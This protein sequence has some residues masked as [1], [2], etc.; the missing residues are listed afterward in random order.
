[1]EYINN[2][3]KEVLKEANNLNLPV[4]K[5]IKND[6]IINK[7]AKS[8]FGCCKKI[9]KGL[10]ESYELELSD[11][12]LRCEEK[13]I[14]QTLAHEI[15]HTCPGCGNHG[16]L[17][18]AYA[19][20]MNKTYGYHIKRTDTAQQ[21]GIEED[22]AN[23]NRLLK[24]NYILICKGCGATIFRRRM[25]SVVKNPSKYRCKCG[26]KLERVK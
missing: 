8:R 16:E 5:K 26:G 17:W 2:L 23:K 6:I 11:R 21:L 19:D 3:F 14:K 12:L 25:S 10:S 15:L 7:R 24:E 20:Q 4:S 18:K 13:F 9:R 1:M 22:T